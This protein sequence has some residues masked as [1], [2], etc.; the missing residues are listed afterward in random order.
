MY[1]E[2]NVSFIFSIQCDN[3]QQSPDFYADIIFP[4][5]GITNILQY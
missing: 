4:N 1:S 2:E 5:E 3:K